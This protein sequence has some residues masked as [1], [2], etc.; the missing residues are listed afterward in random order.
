MSLKRRKLPQLGH[1]QAHAKRRLRLA[2]LRQRHHRQPQ[3]HRARQDREPA[4][5][6]PHLLSTRQCGT[7][8]RRQV[9]SD[10]GTGVGQSEFRQDG[11]TNTCAAGFLDG[12]TTQDGE[13]QFTIRRSGDVQLVYVGYKIPAGLHIDSDAIGVAADI[14]AD[15]PNG[16]LHKL[17][18]ETGKASAIMQFQLGGY[19]PGLQIIGA[20]VKKGEPLEPVRQALTD[21]IESFAT[22]PPTEAEM[23]RVRVSN[24]NAYEK[25]LSDHQRIGI[26][27]SNVLALGDWRL[28]FAGRDQVAAMTSQ[29]VAVAAAS[30]F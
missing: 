18:V 13:R 15:T 12:G 3:R 8:D 28:L 26:A 9:R 2:Q 4:S 11:E 22:T 7:A 14:L 17:L 29:Q 25:L 6:L 1:G 21:A 16:R 5:L 30:Y 19:A 20:V 23:A 24:A 10:Q 27:L